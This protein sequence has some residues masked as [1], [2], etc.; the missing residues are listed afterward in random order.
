MSK[1]LEQLKQE[2]IDAQKNTDALVAHQV[3]RK[4]EWIKAVKARDAAEKAY[5]EL[6]LEQRYAVKLNG[7]VWSYYRWYDN[8][9]YEVWRLREI[10]GETSAR[11]YGPEGECFKPAGERGW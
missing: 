2:M 5:N 3:S 6:S 8:A 11:M 7:E 1:T 4:R 9:K 10:Y